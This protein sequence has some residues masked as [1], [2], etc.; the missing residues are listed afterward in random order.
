[1]LLPFLK[2]FGKAAIAIELSA[3]ASL[4]YIFHQ[5]NTGGPETRR[6]WDQRV[7]FLIDAFYKATGD[8]R[9][10]EHRGNSSVVENGSSNKR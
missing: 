6:K 3:A 5:I 2:R 4:Y 10:I 1:M 9:V 7:P 8:E